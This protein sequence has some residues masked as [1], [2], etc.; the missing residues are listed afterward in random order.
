VEARLSREL[1][2]L[3][4][5]GINDRVSSRLDD[6]LRKAPAVKFLGSV[7][8]E[9]PAKID[10]GGTGVVELDPVVAFSVRVRQALL[11]VGEKFADESRPLLL[12]GSLGRAAEMSEREH[13]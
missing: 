9:V 3:D 6:E 7:C 11:V 2:G 8:Q 4:P 1:I 12:R 13:E 5:G 10:L